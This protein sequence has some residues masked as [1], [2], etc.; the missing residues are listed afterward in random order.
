MSEVITPAQHAVRAPSVT[1]DRRSL[2]IA[3]LITAV[4][5]LNLMDLYCTLTANRMGMLDEMN[6]LAATFI[7]LG[8]TPS[9]IC[10]KI[11]M[12]GCGLGILWKARHNRLVVPACWLLLGTYISLSVLWYMWVCTVRSDL[13]YR[14]ANAMP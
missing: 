14:I 3:Y 6:P 8:L 4:G 2:R 5:I 13:G 12:V 1:V 10:Y 11:L 7:S 9:L